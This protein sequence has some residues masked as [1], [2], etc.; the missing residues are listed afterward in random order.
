MHAWKL[1][2]AK[3]DALMDWWIGG[4]VDWWIGGVTDR[5]ALMFPHGG[6]EA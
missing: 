1:L 3:G 4:L 2:S 5:W 6:E